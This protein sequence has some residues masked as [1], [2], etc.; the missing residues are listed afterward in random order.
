[1]HI[2]VHTK[3]LCLTRSAYVEFTSIEAAEHALSLN[4]TSF[5]SRI[6]KV[7]KMMSIAN[8]RAKL[9]FIIVGWSSKFNY[10]VAV[11]YG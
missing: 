1:M 11:H 5:M 2:E 4:G 7:Y 6:L 9:S 10:M 8:I 3:L